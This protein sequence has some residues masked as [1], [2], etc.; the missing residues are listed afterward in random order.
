MDAAR[1]YVDFLL[2]NSA[3]IG[4]MDTADNGKQRFAPPMVV[5]PWFWEKPTY[6]KNY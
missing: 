6:K 1:R 2:S 4:R 5:L 3:I